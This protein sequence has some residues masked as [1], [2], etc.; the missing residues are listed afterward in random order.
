MIKQY[1]TYILAI[2]ISFNLGV[3]IVGDPDNPVVTIT[4]LVITVLAL[5]VAYIGFKGE[6]AR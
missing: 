1:Y 4:V 2:L 3:V 6:K 5:I